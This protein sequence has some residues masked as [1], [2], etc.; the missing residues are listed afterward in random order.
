MPRRL[1]GLTITRDTDASVVMRLLLNIIIVA[2][3]NDRLRM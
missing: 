3:K 2:V 1:V